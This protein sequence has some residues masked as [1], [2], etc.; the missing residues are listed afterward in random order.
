MQRAEAL[1]KRE[2]R[3]VAERE[4][5]TAQ[6]REDGELVLR[7][8]DRRERVAQRLD[9]F[10]PVER[11]AADQHVRQVARLERAHVGVRH[12]GL[13]RA[14]APEEQADVARR[15][16][17]ARRRRARSRS[18]RSR[19]PA[20]RR[21]PPSRP[22]AIARSASR[23]PCRSRRTAPA[24]AA[25]RSPA[26][27][28]TLGAHRHERHVGR[29]ARRRRPCAA[30]APR[31]P[32]PGSRAR[33]GSSP[34]DA[35]STAPAADEAALDRPR[36]ARRRRAGSGRSIASDR[37]RGRACPGTGRT[38]VQ[39]TSSGSSAASSRRIS[40]CSGSVSW[41]SSTKTCVKRA[42]RSRRT[43]GLPRRR[44]RG[45]QQQVAEVEAAGALLQPLV[46]LDDRPELGAAGAARGR[47]PRRRRTPAGAPARASRSARSAA[48]ARRAR[49]AR[50]PDPAPVLGARELQQLGLEPVVVAAA[51]RLAARHLVDE[52]R[53]LDQRLGEEVGRTRRRPA[54]APSALELRA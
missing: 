8:L 47:R 25:R 40:A 48:F 7:P 54:C 22:A 29:L 18:S 50:E 20:T 19:A 52:L 49:A 23:R 27:S 11:A 46:A 14:E 31:S 5:R 24:P 9:L 32:P 21:T 45:D 30:R 4:E 3:A 17:H 44:S 1:A 51:N 2:Q 34:S 13:E 15:D 26:A 43:A 28:A 41:N 16:R 6:R 37:R 10:A 33:R 12:V 39:S 35:A 42:C 38:R 36:R 53:D